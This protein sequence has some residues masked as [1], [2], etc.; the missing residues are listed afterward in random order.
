MQYWMWLPTVV[1]AVDFQ[2]IEEIA[3]AQEKSLDSRQEK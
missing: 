1:V 2:P 3:S